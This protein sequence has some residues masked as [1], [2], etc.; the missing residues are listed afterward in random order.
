MGRA[1]A[2]EFTGQI[3][4]FLEPIN[5]YGCWCYLDDTYRTTAHSRPVDELD[6]I[7]RD[8]INGY[9]CAT[10]DSENNE[11]E[12]YC[13]A[14]QVTYV[15]FNFFGREEEHLDEDCD[16]LNSDDVCAARACKIEARF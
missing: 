2:R 7:C 8:L 5:G 16:F 9:K 1:S 6:N 15:Q 4:A 14:Q 10:I 13:D 12:L 11:E 3:A